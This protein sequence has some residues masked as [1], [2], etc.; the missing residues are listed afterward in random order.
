AKFFVAERQCVVVLTKSA[1]G[2][3]EQGFRHANR[4]RQTPTRAKSVEFVAENCPKLLFAFHGDHQ[5]S[6]SWVTSRL[7]SSSEAKGNAC[8]SS[9]VTS[10]PTK[11]LVVPETSAIG[12]SGWPSWPTSL[13]FTLIARLNSLVAKTFPRTER[14]GDRL[15]RMISPLSVASAVSPLAI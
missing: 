2:Q 15:T 4:F 8:R 12:P 14:A 11:K 1:L 3:F 7:A 6:L 10:V 13:Y 9:V 5:P